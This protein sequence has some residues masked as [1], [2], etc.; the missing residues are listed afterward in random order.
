MAGW[1]QLQRWWSDTSSASDGVL[2]RIADRLLPSAGGVSRPADAGIG[3]IVGKAIAAGLFLIVLMLVLPRLFGAIFDDSLPRTSAPAANA[4]AVPP[5]AAPA[6]ASP[7]ALPDRDGK[8][9]GSL[10]R[11]VRRVAE[12]QH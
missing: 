4:A 12:V 11:P 8:R 9:E 5:R 1:K 6:T 3:E 10:R 2:D 7:G